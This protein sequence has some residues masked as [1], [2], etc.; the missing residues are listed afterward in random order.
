MSDVKGSDGTKE[1][2]AAEPSTQSWE[3]RLEIA[4]KQRASALADARVAAAP[5]TAWELQGNIFQDNEPVEPGE[6][7]L[8]QVVSKTA[9]PKVPAKRR[10]GQIPHRLA[11]IVAGAMLCGA[12]LQ[13]AATSV[14][15]GWRS[16][17]ASAQVS[18]NAATFETP[19]GS[20]SDNQRVRAGHDQSEPAVPVI[21]ADEPD[22][23][24]LKD[25]EVPAV[26]PPKPDVAP[27]PARHVP[28][29]AAISME[30]LPP[31]MMPGLG[32]AVTPR[33]LPEFV[34]NYDQDTAIPKVE[35]ARSEISSKPQKPLATAVSLFV[36]MGV[37]N[38]A[39][40]N[41]YKILS[42]GRT[43][44]VTTARVG[45]SVKATQV[46]Y[47]HS[48]DA[49]LADQAAESLGG[50]SRDFTNSGSKTRPGH[51]EVYL[52]GSGG[53]RARTYQQRT[54]PVERILARIFEEFR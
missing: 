47:Y 39:S 40:A 9:R 50:I 49:E 13:W 21:W 35:V 4:R 8:E 25:I 42:S 1:D 17:D 24:T 53:G 37:A 27:G 19:T 26:R 7:K 29:P 36:P 30:A 44:V 20:D 41:A 14:W 34:A 10:Q 5:K 22:I 15:A 2:I 43:D 6:S 45:Y 18:L 48:D 32:E 52:A 54:D 33:P 28:P 51:I 46:R 31:P 3:A 11:F 16:P 12:F 38:E 23:L